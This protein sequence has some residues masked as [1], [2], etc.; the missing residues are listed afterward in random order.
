M[1]IHNTEVAA[2]FNQIADLLEIEGAN[3]FRV[4]AYRNA[5]RTVGGLSKNIADLLQKNFDLT[6]LPGIGKDLAEK[7]K[8]IIET[9]DLPLLKEIKARTPPILSELMKIEGLGPK[10]VQIL[11]KKL[12]IHNLDDLKQAID[13]GK[14]RKLTG[15]GEKTEA[16]I[17]AGI[18]HQKEYTKRFK[19]AEALPIAEKLLA[20]LK[21]NKAVKKITCAGSY[22]RHKETI[23]DLDFLITTENSQ[24]IMQY[25]LAYPDIT[26]V[27]S[28]GDTR[29]TVH[30]HSGIQVDLRVVPPENYGAALLYLTGSKEHNISLRKIAV[31]KKLKLNE[32]GIYKGK[33]ILASRTE[34]AI[35]QA[36]GLRYIEPEL[37]EDH[38]E[39]AAAQKNKL[40]TLIRLQDL[41]G[42]LHCHTQATDG[43][44][45]LEAMAKTAEE[46]GYEYFAIT[47]HSQH[48]TIAHGLS[49]KELLQQ[50]K[51]IDR[52]NEK[53]KGLVILKSSEIDIL[54]D[55]SLDWPES[56]LQELDLT[57]CSIHS[58]FNLSLEKQTE[59]IIRAMDNPYFN[60][61]GHA[62]GRL[63]NR[64]Q[65]YELNM[66][67]I[68][69]AA[70][71]RGCVLEI[72]AQ[73]DRLDLNEVFCK[74]A[75]ELDVKL[76]LSTDAHS[77]EQMHNMRFG[78]YQARRGWI[79]RG[80]VINAL[81]LAGLKKALKRK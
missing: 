49:Q 13:T 30:L 15:F 64:R 5:A 37:R 75:K 76:A 31:Q 38:G 45:T 19:L 14:I 6:T 16:H 22:R 65:P 55:G 11:Y 24:K 52:L 71:E 21:K 9:G 32:Y 51:A 18:Q 70:K 72:N 7:I 33:K 60:V 2:K 17:R 80:D 39:I 43:N 61:L 50:F 66:E 47:D 77:T 58:K 63:I 4:R 41:R 10:R 20:Y 56:L 54:E 68:M 53:L 12:G 36:L 48:L 69:L 29:S 28:Q 57:I 44:A 1:T 40:P 62:T 23:G 35:Y 74:Q 73:P 3:S 78:L 79:E 25:F 46:L 81:P 26:Q 59:R 67:K 34:E 42:D 8:T 27:L